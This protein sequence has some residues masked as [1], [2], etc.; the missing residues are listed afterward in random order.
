MLKSSKL[1]DRF[2]K[3][4][5]KLE[6]N[7]T[8]ALSGLQSDMPDFDDKIDIET[9][10]KEALMEKVNSTPV[11]FEYSVVRQ[12][13][14]IK[15]FIDGKLN[16][17]DAALSE[18]KKNELIEKL[19]A[20]IT[21]FGPLDYLLS[22]ENVSAV[23]VNEQKNVHIEIAGKVLNTEITL[24]DDQLNLILNNIFKSCGVKSDTS[25]SVWNLKNENLQI[26]IITTPVCENG[27][28]IV[29]RKLLPADINT[30]FG[31]NI[32]SK[33]IFDFI[34]S[35]VS[36]NKN[37]V[38][39]GDI[40]SGKTF[41]LDVLLSAV[42]SDKRFVLIEDRPLISFE[43]ANFM[44]FFLPDNS[45]EYG[46]FCSNILSLCPEYIVTDV[47]TI[48]SDFSETKGYISTLRASSIDSA[49]TKLTAAFMSSKSLTEKYAKNKVLT[50]F[51]Y[52]VQIN[53]M[54]DGSSKITSV[55]EL[56]PARTAALS[57][58]IIAKFVDGQYITEIPQP[59][60]S[61]R[62]EALTHHGGA[63]YSR[64][65]RSN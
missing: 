13:E 15:T 47:N 26:T 33:E 36:E 2:K 51:D 48:L 10:I 43:G 11:W 40:N 64:F 22:Q 16:T 65:Y 34:V 1:S 18:D 7:S 61:I 14:L 60:T 54:S 28:N 50:D 19:Y 57:V 41:L 20:L 38:I 24:S 63:M 59:L 17:L 6:E 29:I 31:R 9:E 55:V 30:F 12:K 32:T 58:K 56:K 62:A 23:F 52:I 37:I 53:K 8:P 27:T 3:K 46:K 45:A 35:A 21:G 39:S 5:I 4:E 49:I 25:R 42:A 44:K